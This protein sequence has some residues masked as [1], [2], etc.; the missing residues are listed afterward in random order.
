MGEILA[1]PIIRRVDRK[2]VNI[3]LASSGPLQLDGELFSQNDLSTKISMSSGFQTV[4]LGEKLFVHLL[5]IRPAA[6]QSF[7]LDEL[8][9]YDILSQLADGSSTSLVRNNPD[10]LFAGV[11]NPALPS[12]FIPRK[13]KRVLHGSCRKPHAKQPV[14]GRKKVDQLSCGAGLVEKHIDNLGERPAALFLTGDQIYA[15][16]VAM[17]VL[18]MLVNQAKVL[19]GWDEI[20]PV[21]NNGAEVTPANAKLHGRMADLKL[22]R[23]GITSGQAHD[24]L[25]AFGEFSAMYL[26]AWGGETSL[27][28][29]EKVISRMH[30]SSPGGHTYRWDRERASAFF[31]ARQDVRR[32]FANIP[33]YMIFDDHEVTDD[34]NLNPKWESKACGNPFGKRMMSNALA[35]YWAFQAWGNDPDKFDDDFIDVIEA[36]VNHQQARSAQAD[37]FDAMMLDKQQVDRWSYTLPTDPFTVVLD[38]RMQRKSGSDGPSGACI[39]MN[40]PACSWLQ[41]VLEQEQNR[42]GSH[43]PMLL[44]SASP[45]FGFERMEGLQDIAVKLGL[46]EASIDLESW[47]EGFRHLESVLM[48]Q[49]CAIKSTTVLSG[50]VHYS[51]S[52]YGQFYNADKS[53]QIK[54]VQLTSSPISNKPTGGIVGKALLRVK[55]GEYP[56]MKRPQR[57]KAVVTSL[58]QLGLVYFSDDG[59]T[60]KHVLLSRKS[61]SDDPEH[62]LVYKF[63]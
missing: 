31:A 35:A 38:T 16:D 15:D 25:L 39:L 18:A 5:R 52:R 1:G 56:N 54:A 21:D 63:D 41:Q 50:D 58:N 48:K 7:P 9:C 28:V 43:Y 34:W 13:L 26:A 12:F 4:K 60:E 47:K 46:S 40:E 49:T 32:L 51:F 6:N 17:P 57:S 53:R 62:A 14:L 55:D 29:Y 33:V 27:P 3:W 44:I 30:S 20:M 37:A 24:H 11:G 42:R 19:T 45:V 22:G 10:V 23:H 36:H 61:R 2:E 8:L 59:T